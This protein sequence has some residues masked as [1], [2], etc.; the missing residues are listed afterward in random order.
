ML[1]ATAGCTSQADAAVR[2]AALQCLTTAL[3]TPSA[4][5]AMAQLLT[6]HIVGAAASTGNDDIGNWTAGLQQLPRSGNAA[7]ASGAADASRGQPRHQHRS[8]AASWRPAAAGS[9]GIAD[10]APGGP[11]AEAAGS[12]RQGSLAEQLLSIATGELWYQCRTS[13]AAATL[14]KLPFPFNS[15]TT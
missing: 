8:D 11:N 15:L 6:G 2:L 3:G 4:D 12:Q 10:V 14:L 7:A 1:A 5:A 9:A 13:C